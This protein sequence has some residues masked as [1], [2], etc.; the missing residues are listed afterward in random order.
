M[1][2]KISKLVTSSVPSGSYQLRKPPSL[3]LP[4]LRHSPIPPQI[5]EAL[6]GDQ[7][8]IDRFLANHSA[9]FYYWVL[10]L[11]FIFSP[12]LAYN[13]S[14]LIEAHAVDTC[15]QGVTKLCGMCAGCVRGVCGVY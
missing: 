6:G 15:K 11:L 2:P 9:I 7:L 3:L 12:S 8:W 10:V 5:M 14:E 4:P 13:F 1:P